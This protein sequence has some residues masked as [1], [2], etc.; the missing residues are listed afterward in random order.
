ML[1]K[2][3]LEYPSVAKAQG[4]Q[5]TVT[6]SIELLK[7]GRVGDVEVEK[8]SGYPVLDQAAV[9]RHQPA[10]ENGVPVTRK[11]NFDIEFRLDKKKAVEP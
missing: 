5:G 6:L 2:P 1:E 4:W 10:A 11:I 8:S 3:V 9:E 7:N